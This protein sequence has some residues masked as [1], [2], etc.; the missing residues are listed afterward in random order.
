MGRSLI[1]KSAKDWLSFKKLEL[2]TNL[3]DDHIL[4]FSANTFE[5]LLSTN[6]L[7]CVILLKSIVFLSDSKLVFQSHLFCFD[8][9]KF[10]Y[11]FK[12]EV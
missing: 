9:F 1:S 12:I 11:K 8:K 10:L 4:A 7:M 2:E 5:L 6:F 3:L